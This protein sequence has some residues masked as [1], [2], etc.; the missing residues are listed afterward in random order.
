MLLKAGFDLA[1]SKGSHRIYIKGNSRVTVPFHSNKVLHPKVVG[2]II[3]TIESI[4][5]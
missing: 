4:R 3:N 1:R 2:Q 5:D